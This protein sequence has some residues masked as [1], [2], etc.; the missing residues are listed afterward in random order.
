MDEMDDILLPFL[1]FNNIIFII[2]FII[3]LNL[4]RRFYVNI[5]ILSLLFLL[6][7]DILFYI[8]YHTI[9]VVLIPE[10]FIIFLGLFGRSFFPPSVITPSPKFLKVA[11]AVMASAVVL[12]LVL[13]FT[14]LILYF[15]QMKTH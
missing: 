8:G 7:S 5:S 2:N 13:F 1:C 9:F 12:T 11:L 14:F 15:I 6:L 3:F 4:K 10:I